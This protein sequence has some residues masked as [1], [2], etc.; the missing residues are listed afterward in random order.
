MTKISRAIGTLVAAFSLNVSVAKSANQGIVEASKANREEQLMN[1]L[2][3]NVA[4]T[5]SSQYP[6]LA[7]QSF[8]QAGST[9]TPV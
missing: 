2:L 9:G 4:P 3:E 1:Q 7:D 5:F 8:T 6:D